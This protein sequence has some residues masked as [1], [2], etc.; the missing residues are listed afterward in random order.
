M[1]YVG[2][3]VTAKEMRVYKSVNDQGTDQKTH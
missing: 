3:V 1:Q 2:I